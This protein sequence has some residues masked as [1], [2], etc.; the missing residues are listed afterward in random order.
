[1]TSRPGFAIGT[2]A[3]SDAQGGLLVAWMFN[4]DTSHVYGQRLSG[5]GDPL[6]GTA[7]VEPA[8]STGDQRGA[9]I[10]TGQAGGAL[11]LWQH[12]PSS[13]VASVRIQRFAPD[14][15]TQW[16]ESGL[17]LTSKTGFVG[18]PVVVPDGAGGVHAVWPT[19]AN[20]DSTDVDLLYQ[21]VSAAGELLTP[22]GSFFCDAPGA[23]SRLVGAAAP[24]GDAVFAWE[25]TRDEAFT[26][27]DIRIQRISAKG[28]KRWEPCGLLVC[29]H[30][31]IRN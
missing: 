20:F 26:M 7:G 29:A 12:T 14:G 11:M 10:H 15:S 4:G 28:V 30:R 19:Y 22:S 23:Q 13:G 27:R 31:A 1:M 16:G 18:V 2:S 5:S 24:G 17:S 8:P 25:D 6:W 21:H 9:S 3:A